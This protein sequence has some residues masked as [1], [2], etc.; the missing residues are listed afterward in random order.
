MK[1]FR[2]K[3]N[4]RFVLSFLLVGILLI[5]FYKVVSDFKGFWGM[6]D[7]LNII[8]SPFIYG[9]VIAYIF[10]PVYNFVV[11]RSY[12]LF[13]RKLKVGKS[14]TLARALGSLIIVLLIVGIF[15]GFTAMLVPQL[16]DSLMELSKMLPSSF[17]T[18]TYWINEVVSNISDPSVSNSISRMIN[19]ALEATT[20]WVNTSLLPNIWGYLSNLSSGIMATMTT[21]MNLIFGILVAVYILNEKEIFLAQGKKIIISIR[22]EEK[23]KKYKKIYEYTN[24]VFSKYINGKILD[25]VIVGIICFVTMLIMGMPYAVLVST[26]VGVTNIIPFFGPFIGAI[27]GVIIIAIVS[28]VQALYFVIMI[29]LLQ[30][31]DGNVIQPLILGNATG[32]SSFWVMFAIIVGGG[33][34][35]VT[36]MI[37]GV[38]I[39]AIIYYVIGEKVSEGLKAKDLP[40]KTV[41][42]ETFRA[43]DINKKEFDEINMEYSEAVH[44]KS[45]KKLRKSQKKEEK[46]QNRMNK[47]NKGL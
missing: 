47:N 35:G 46:K 14:L 24:N 15:V 36:G 25:S 8:L 9:F 27:P 22:P 37:L 43:Y 41:E 38:P 1:K 34:F 3:I 17:K 40:A 12:R 29:F 20:N 16:V 7:T 39:F 23:V 21:I 10:A 6:I 26:I 2:E 18:F 45:I 4:N 19:N 13:S 5:V 31:L 44:N 11:G 30:Q 28:P 32:L 42:Y 33:F